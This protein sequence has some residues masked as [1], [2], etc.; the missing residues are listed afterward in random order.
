MQQTIAPIVFF[1]VRFSPVYR[2]LS[3]KIKPGNVTASIQAIQKKWAQLLPGSSFE[4]TFMDDTLKRLYAG[5]IQL[6]KAAYTSTA[7]AFII[8]LLGMLGLVSLNIQ[9]RTKEIGIRKVLGSSVVGIIA[10]FLKDFLFVILIA[11]VV[12]CPLAYLLMKGWLN[13]YA[14]RIPITAQPFILSMVAL[15]SLTAILIS[16][17]TRNAANANPVKSLRTE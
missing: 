12:A 13:D 11:G 17:Q 15:G 2:Y 6:K 4:Y 9:K 3:F 8:V 5:E 16:L 10:L 14:Y 1:N 7:L